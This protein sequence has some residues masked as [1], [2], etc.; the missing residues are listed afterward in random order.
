[1]HRQVSVCICSS[2]SRFNRPWIQ[3]RKDA[4]SN[5]IKRRSETKRDSSVVLDVTRCA[6]IEITLI[7]TVDG[8][9]GEQL[10]GCCAVPNPRGYPVEVAGQLDTRPIE[11]V[12]APVADPMLVDGRV[13][14][15]CLDACA[16]SERCVDYAIEKLRHLISVPVE[17]ALLAMRRLPPE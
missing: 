9:T 8:K 15:S 5:R 14:K 7:R 17:E 11:I 13:L 3:A 4:S 12:R 6:N 2:D 1:I 10:N 16:V